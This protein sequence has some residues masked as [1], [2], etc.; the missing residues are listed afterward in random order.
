MNYIKLLAFFIVGSELIYLSETIIYLPRYTFCPFLLFTFPQFWNRNIIIMSNLY[1]FIENLL[2]YRSH[3]EN[4]GSRLGEGICGGNNNG[5]VIVPPMD[6]D[7]SLYHY[8]ST[9]KWGDLPFGGWYWTMVP[10]YGPVAVKNFQTV[11][12]II[13]AVVATT[14]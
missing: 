7:I 3:G 10:I 1:V 5:W 14:F 8:T 13:R 4:V 9:W 11:F 2:E 12:F 6:A